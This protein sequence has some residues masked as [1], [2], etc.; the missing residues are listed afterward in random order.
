M[1]PAAEDERQQTR[2]RKER[3]A[4]YLFQHLPLSIAK[5]VSLH[6]ERFKVFGLEEL[7]DLVD[8]YPLSF[9][10]VA[11]PLPDLSGWKETKAKKKIYDDLASML[12]RCAG[13][14]L[15]T[16][17]MR[18]DITLFEQSSSFSWDLAD[19]FLR[20]SAVEAAT[21][22]IVSSSLK[23]A[24]LEKK[25]RESKNDAQLLRL[26]SAAFAEFERRN[27]ASF[28]AAECVAQIISNGKALLGL[29]LSMSRLNLP[30]PALVESKLLDALQRTTSLRY[31]HMRDT[32]LDEPGAVLLGKAMANH[33]SL[34]HID[35]GV[36]EIG[37]DG[38]CAFAESLKTNTRLRSLL[39]GAVGASE[40]AGY[41]LAD[42]LLVNETLQMLYMKDDDLGPECAT[43]LA[44][45]LET[46]TTLMS[47]TL[48]YC[49]LTSKGCQ[50]FI[51]AL[52]VN[53]TLKSLSLSY[54]S[55]TLH[56]IAELTRVAKE[57]GTL[58]SLVLMDKNVLKERPTGMLSS[59]VMHAFA[60]LGSNYAW[61][62]SSQ[63]LG[64][65]Y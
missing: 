15:Q 44:S 47:L 31:L 3:R 5:R 42:A 30:C 21:I 16:F 36:N 65:K 34:E 28:E 51:S 9:L 18:L 62:M 10:S 41:A 58:H 49:D 29:D 64:I 57:G 12:Q 56:D 20:S 4:T 55:A 59:K 54:N 23:H 32:G 37:D 19:L 39:F 11:T 26:G 43:A 38:V 1:K 2:R 24:C 46:N 33:Q 17:Q 27:E 45:M 7:E 6:L 14:T 13:S 60:Q 8:A 61:H 63:S 35:V 25:L 53:R 48:D 22:E 40:R 50:S 52:E